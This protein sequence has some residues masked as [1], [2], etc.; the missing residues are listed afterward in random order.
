MK[1]VVLLLTMLS[2]SASAGRPV[3][4]PL[5]EVWAYDMPGTRDIRE[6]DD[7]AS[8]LIPPPA[9]LD[10]TL[11]QRSAFMVRGHG[12]PALEAAHAVLV[13]GQKPP[14]VL[15][16]GEPV[17]AVFFA[18]NYPV[19]DVYLNSVVV[20]NRRV[21]F[22]YSFSKYSKHDGNKPAQH[23]AIVPLAI[24]KPG[25]FE[26]VVLRKD[27]IG[28]SGPTADGASWLEQHVCRS[29]RCTVIQGE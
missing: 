1:K 3:E 22:V 27:S 19:V 23:I 24:D 8:T 9:K 15:K 4:L 21:E 26:I 2:A 12:R 25:G 10:P 18:Y 17:S 29:G 6:L 5:S 16:A 11:P 14:A 7:P 20:R 13:G 28:V